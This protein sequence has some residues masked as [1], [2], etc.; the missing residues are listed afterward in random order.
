MRG[1]IRLY[2]KT[3]SYLSVNVQGVLTECHLTMKARNYLA[4]NVKCE[5]GSP[6]KSEGN[7]QQI[8]LTHAK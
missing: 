1:W 3:E 8:R 2:T 6:P 7:N 4:V 5:D